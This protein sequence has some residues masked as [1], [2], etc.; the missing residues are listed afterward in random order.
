MV[1]PPAWGVSAVSV[2]LA[3][4]VDH[5][6]D[7][8]LCGFEVAL[9]LGDSGLGLFLCFYDFGKVID[10]LAV[11]TRA[12]VKCRRNFNLEQIGRSDSADAGSFS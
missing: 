12:R 4:L 8:L 1:L 9:S 5:L 11:L 7:G 2:L 6:G 3:G 10:G